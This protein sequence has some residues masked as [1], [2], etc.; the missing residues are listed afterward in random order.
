MFQAGA[1]TKIVKEITGHISDAVHKYQKT[2][3]DQKMEVSKIIQEDIK[4]IKLS[5]ASPME[6][7]E[8]PKKV[9][10][11]D[12]CKLEKLVLPI[13]VEKTQESGETEICNKVSTII[14]S[15]I[16][17]VGDR[18]AKLTIQVELNNW[19]ELLRKE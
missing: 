10:L 3:T 2:S 19:G 12:R 18:K 7:V 4:P 11:E 13:K 9:T 15:A 5:E 6:I 8:S 1:D 14:N 16:E 17:A